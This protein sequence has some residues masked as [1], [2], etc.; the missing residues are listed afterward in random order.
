MQIRIFKLSTKKKTE[1]NK[2][3]SEKK[4]LKIIHE[5]ISSRVV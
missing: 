3:R 2:A 4:F 1:K 5:H